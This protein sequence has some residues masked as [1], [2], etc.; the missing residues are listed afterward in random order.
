MSGSCT[1]QRFQSDGTMKE[2]PPFDWRAI[3]EQRQSKGMLPIWPRNVF[4][5]PRAL[6]RSALF[7][8][9]PR[10]GPVD[11]SRRSIAS[12]RDVAVQLQGDHLEQTDCDVL[13]GAVDFAQRLRVPLS[14][15]YSLKRSAL[16]QSIG[17]T[18]GCS[19]Y[20]WLEAGLRRLESATVEISVSSGRRDPMATRF[21]LL[22][23]VR[24]DV[25]T[26]DLILKLDPGILPLMHADGCAFIDREARMKI[27]AQRN[28]T[29]WIQAYACS[30]KQGEQ[31]LSFEKFQAWSGCATY[32]SRDFAD[33][34]YEALIELNRTREIALKCWDAGKKC[35]TWIRQ[36]YPD[37]RYC[38]KVAGTEG[39][40]WAV[41]NAP[42]LVELL[43]FDRRSGGG[44]CL[45]GANDVDALFRQIVRQSRRD[46]A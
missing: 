41:Q 11:Q 8:A 33:A 7:S 37:R 44:P 35:V 32:R 17:R 12:R 18:T 22:E 6:A 16:L 30:H 10:R 34:L 21:R 23:S 46:A 27:V 4:G 28:L 9:R 1:H 3:N 39:G 42:V 45:K 29:K 26:N 2:Q 36:S 43:R 25:H 19:D 20:R 31:K 38:D 14:E 15:E 5:F 13:L 40:E 24:V